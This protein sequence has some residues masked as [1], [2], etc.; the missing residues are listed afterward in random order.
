MHYNIYLPLTYFIWLVD[1]LTEVWHSYGIVCMQA[2]L[3]LHYAQDFRKYKL[4]LCSTL[5]IRLQKE[6]TGGLDNV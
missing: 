5:Q 6:T 2:S 4:P 3:L 1:N